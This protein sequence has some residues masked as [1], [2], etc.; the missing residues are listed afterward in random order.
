MAH[1]DP[2]EGSPGAVDNATGTAALLAI[3][4]LLVE[5][6][7]P[8]SVEMVPING[9]DHDSV[10]GEHCFVA[11]NTGRWE[12]LVLAINLDAVG[13]RDART[14]VSLY[15]CPPWPEAHVNEV[16]AR[17]PHVQHGEAWYE[18]DHSIVAMQ[19]RPAVALTSTTFGEQCA[20]ITHTPRDTLEVVAAEPVA[21][22]AEFVADVLRS[23]P[24]ETQGSLA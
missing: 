14:A 8:V 4:E 5:Q 18:S 20:S 19:G 9:E 24:A 11:D 23:L 3:G 7:S 6:V 22:A 16:L 2:K 21:A 15:G 12:E 13:A 1:L 17:H 10:G